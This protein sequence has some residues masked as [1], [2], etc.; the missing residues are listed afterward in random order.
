[1]VVGVLLLPQATNI[2]HVDGV[3]V[4]VAVLLV[5]GKLLLVQG[6]QTN[7]CVVTNANDHDPAGL[8]PAALVLLFGEGDVNLGH[9][10][11]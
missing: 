9:V 4:R 7:S 10:I 6:L 2:V 3:E 8:A 1:M 11:G 5:G